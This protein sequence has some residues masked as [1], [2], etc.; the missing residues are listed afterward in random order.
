[1]NPLEGGFSSWHSFKV[2]PV[3][4]ALFQS[5]TWKYYLEPKKMILS[6]WHSTNGSFGGKVGVG[7][8]RRDGL[9]VT[10]KDLD[11]RQNKG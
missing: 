7:G 4:V 11:H 1:M 8:G 9:E 6:K 10:S 5:G 2:A 3:V